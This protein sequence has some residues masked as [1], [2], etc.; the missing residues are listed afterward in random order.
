MKCWVFNSERE[1]DTEFGG[2]G[3]GGSNRAGSDG[4]TWVSRSKHSNIF[5][6]RNS[7]FSLWR[8]AANHIV[9]GNIEF[10]NCLFQN[11]STVF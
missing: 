2:G 9:P 1:Q 7:Q 5:L 11:E 10:G 8:P 4:D 3:G 6:E